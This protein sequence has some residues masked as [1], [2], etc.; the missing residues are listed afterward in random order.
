MKYNSVIS[1]IFTLH[2]WLVSFV[3]YFKRENYKYKHVV[4]D[5]FVI[6][7]RIWMVLRFKICYSLSILLTSNTG[8]NLTSQIKFS[9]DILWAPLRKLLIEGHAMLPYGE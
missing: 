5:K 1:K 2:L 8:Y 6:K 9:G 7:L 4:E 3:D